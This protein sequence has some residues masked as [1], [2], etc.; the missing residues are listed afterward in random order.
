MWLQTTIG[1]FSIVEKPEDRAEG[2]LTVRARD[3]S[4]LESLKASALPSLGEIKS[5]AETDYPFR[6]RAS[7]PD[8]AAAF[9]KLALSIDYSNFKAEI[10]KRQGVQREKVYHQVWDVLRT[11]QTEPD[12]PTAATKPQVGPAMAPTPGVNAYG[13]VL[14]GWDGKVL[15]RE[16]KGHFDGYVWTFPKGKVDGP[17]DHGE[18]CA[19]REV[20]EETGYSAEIIAKLPGVYRGGTSQTE[21]F[22][23][24]PVGEPIAFDKETQSIIWVTFEVARERIGETTNS[25]G[26]ARDLMVLADAEKIWM[27]LGLAQ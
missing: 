2:T 27:K 14:V 6:A 17:G 26:R 3:I 8:V 21:F 15:L 12:K 13:G 4:D 16:P 7:K 24:R 18:P 25:G 10:S 19:L 23:M 9:V 20:L 1:F 22:L 11:L 5:S